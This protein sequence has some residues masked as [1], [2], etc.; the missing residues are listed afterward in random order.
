MAEEETTRAHDGSA[1]SGLPGKE[2]AL[3]DIAHAQTVA[4]EPDAI[5]GELDALEGGVDRRRGP[6]LNLGRV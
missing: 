2:V 1:E 6:G 4:A 5:V 3:N